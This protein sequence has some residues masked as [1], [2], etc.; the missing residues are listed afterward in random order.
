MSTQ[1]IGSM[2]SYSSLTLNFAFN[3]GTSISQFDKV[4]VIKNNALVLL[5]EVASHTVS[6]I[7]LSSIGATI[8]S[9]NDLIVFVKNSVAESY[10]S[11]GYYMSVKLENPDTTQ[12]Q[13]FAVTATEFKSYP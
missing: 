3:I 6:S 9:T 7:T 10:G 5:G 4:Y 1:G 2:L 11:R 13:L 12:V 8:P